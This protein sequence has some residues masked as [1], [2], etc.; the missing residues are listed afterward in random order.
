[1][2]LSVLISVVLR[3]KG[4]VVRAIKLVVLIADVDASQDIQSLQP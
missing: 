4:M 3:K 1:M 2:H